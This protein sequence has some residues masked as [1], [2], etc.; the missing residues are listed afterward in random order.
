MD[1]DD[2]AA[3][4]RAA[5][6]F[7]AERVAPMV[8]FDGRDGDLTRLGTVL[9]QAG[10]IGLMAS[11]DAGAAG[12][13]LGVWGSLCRTDG[14]ALSLRTL[15]EVASACAGVASCLHFGGLGALALASFEDAPASAGLA[16]F[17]HSRMLAERRWSDA[18]AC[19]MTA[20]G[21][22]HSLQ[23]A[24]HF[25]HAA[26]GAKA[27]AV[28][29][30][31]S[32]GL[33]LAL[34]QADAPGVQRVEVGQ[35]TGLA[36]CD[37]F[38]LELHRVA[39]SSSRRLREVDAKPWLRRLWLGLC[40]I[41]VGNARGALATASAYAEQRRQGG[42]RIMEHPAVQLLLGGAEARVRVA[43]AA[44]K[45]AQ[46][47]DLCDL[48]D[49]RSAAMLKV[50][51]LEDCFQAVNDSLQ[52]LGGYGYMEDYRL[53]KR[54]RDALTLRSAAGRADDLLRLVATSA[55]EEA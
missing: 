38:H 19:T 43:S 5:G 50:R 23:G 9:A 44:L 27:F 31:G 13:E 4:V 21:D 33:E 6:Q 10:E 51:V 41:G 54:L 47:Q 26:P 28:L 34:I 1:L 2:L 15:E 49:L 40:A 35:R 42:R 18:V 11:G 48:D 32:T 46:R 20:E 45:S 53:E 30:K 55:G 36:A 7:S 14:P 37:V 39:V 8:G 24:K 16:L 29:A 17:D 25:V 22:V 12:H 3:V 52:V